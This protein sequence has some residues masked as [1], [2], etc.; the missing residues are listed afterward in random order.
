MVTGIPLIEGA[1]LGAIERRL[2]GV[3]G[4]EGCLKMSPLLA[5]CAMCLIGQCGLMEQRVE[6]HHD[7]R[8]SQQI[9]V[10]VYPARS[11]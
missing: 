9:V 10:K 7:F 4:G 2:G 8:P 5:A 1:V 11:G 3:S 6:G